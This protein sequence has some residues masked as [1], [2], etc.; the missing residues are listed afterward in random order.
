MSAASLRYWEPIPPEEVAASALRSTT[1][2]R[3]SDALTQ[4]GPRLT[5]GL[6]TR[7]G[8]RRQPSYLGFSSG[9]G[10]AFGAGAALCAGAGLG[11]GADLGAG[12][13]RGAGSGLE[14]AVTF[15]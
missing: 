2:S 10:S 9:L 3:S 7:S 15:G 6:C 11:A 13:A 1:P 4:K 5:V 8:D 14:A 12:A